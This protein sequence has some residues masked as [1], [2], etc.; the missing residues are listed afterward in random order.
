[1]Y[2]KCCRLLKGEV[3]E[4]SIG[5]GIFGMLPCFLWLKSSLHNKKT[6]E[7]RRGSQTKRPWSC[8]NLV[9]DARFGE[10]VGGEKGGGQEVRR[11][12]GMHFS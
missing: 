6:N 8:A 3:Y 7:R 4:V 2:S 5:R 11:V 12:V 9:W 10:G 1:M